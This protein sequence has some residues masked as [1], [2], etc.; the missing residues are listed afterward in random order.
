MKISMKEYNLEYFKS[1]DLYSWDEI[2]EVITDMEIDMVNL[3]DKITDL[4]LDL[5]SNYE[6]IPVSKQVE[7][8]DRDFIW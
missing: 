7:V 5:E 2:I 8:S 4:E 3:K 1:K 6:R